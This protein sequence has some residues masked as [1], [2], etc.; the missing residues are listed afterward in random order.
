MQKIDRTEP[1]PA[2]FQIPPDYAVTESV[3]EPRDRRN[4]SAPSPTPSNQP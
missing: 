1:D 2:L 4:Q 3:A